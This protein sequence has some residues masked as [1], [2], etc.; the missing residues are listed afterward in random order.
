MNTRQS[1]C[2]FCPLGCEIAFR[3]KGTAVTGPEF[4]ADEK[5]PFG[6]RICA[7]GLYGTEL[8]NH[9]QRVST[10]LVN[11]EGMLRETSWDT[12][13]NRVV[14]ALQ[15]VINEHG[16]GAVA[17]VTEPTRSTEDI[18]AV[19]RLAATLGTDAVSCAFEP[20]DW[21]LVLSG[22]SAGVSAIE[23]SN[24]VIVF[25]DVFF[26]HPVIAKEIIDAKYMARGNSLFVVDPR[27]SNT[28]WY[29]SE[30]VQNRPGTEALLLAC[31]LKALKASGK[32][33]SDA[34]LWLDSVD[35]QM[36]LDATGVTR[37][38]VAR[39][40]NAFVTA[41][42]AALVVAPPVRG[43]ADVA[44]IARLACQFAR[45]AGERKDCVLLPSGGNV[46]GAQEVVLR[47]NWKPVSTLISELEEGRYRAVL[48]LGADLLDAFPSSSLSRAMSSLD[49]YASVSLFRGGSEQ[50]AAVVLA[51]SSWLESDGSCTLFDGTALKW[52]AV[53]PPS[54]G[55]LALGDVVMRLESALG[56]A[57]AQPERSSGSSRDVQ[58]CEISDA[59]L[60]ERLASVTGT[61]RSRMGEEL[62]LITLPAT[63]HS[64]A[65]SFT[66]WMKWAGEMFPAGFVEISTADATAW[67]IVD[68]ESV[69]LTAGD[70]QAQL[71]ARVTDR[72]AQGVLAAPGY[73][74]EVRAL[75]AWQTGDDGW[76]STGPG[77][78]RVYRKQ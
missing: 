14:T 11:R 46:R 61:M 63:G 72:L 45:A 8:L 56:K 25:G 58:S 50:M 42:K 59:R 1:T 70:A 36:L 41:D 62:V 54:W 31:L 76:F 53:G 49:L 71:C 12:A 47:N 67:G 20:Q 75:F 24:C 4:C 44:L 39:M 73:D 78:V 13:I 16:P 30:H 77:T 68:G 51:G 10:P 43:M 18:E 3:V 57:P 64:G 52:A 17:I 37:D 74:P 2:L 5:T 60:I 34:L 7:R 65:G 27:R 26:T 48:S 28:A 22:A 6:A 19:G 21:P 55:T 38:L 9:P 33:A 66:S 29:S 35:E 23:E 15:S 40:A 32:V 69:I